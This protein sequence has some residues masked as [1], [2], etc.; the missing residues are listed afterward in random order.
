M[1]PVDART[2]LLRARL[3]EQIEGDKTKQELRIKT[4]NTDERQVGIL[5]QDDVGYEDD[6]TLITERGNRDQMCD[7]WGNYDIATE[8]RELKI[9]GVKV[10][11]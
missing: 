2:I 11:Y 5:I 10:P 4:N 3:R 6:A 9:Q 1:H 8:T 7:R